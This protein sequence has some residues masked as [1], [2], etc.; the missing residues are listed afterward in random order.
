MA[1]LQDRN[2]PG[3]PVSKPQPLHD[4]INPACIQSNPQALPLEMWKDRE[5]EVPLL[6]MFVAHVIG[7]L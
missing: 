4:R 7:I 1:S 3:T 5:L 6:G 2:A